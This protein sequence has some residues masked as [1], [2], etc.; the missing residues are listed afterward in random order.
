MTNRF[1]IVLSALGF[2]LLA[3]PSLAAEVTVP[4]RAGVHDRFNRIVLDWT[5]P[6]KYTMDQAAGQVS[7]QFDH[8]ANLAL[9]SF[10]ATNPPYIRDLTSENNAQ[11]LLLRFSIPQ[12]SRVQAFWSGRKV[13]F[14]VLLMS[15]DKPTFDQKPEEQKPAAAVT[16]PEKVPEEKPASAVLPKE[17]AGPAPDPN[18]T[19]GPQQA[20]IM[21]NIPTLA[22]QMDIAAAAQK[23]AAEQA[24][25]AKADAAT[26]DNADKE[27]K[28][29]QAADD[30]GTVIRFRLLE[31]SKMAVFTRS[32][33]LW[34]VLSPVAKNAVPQ[35]KG[36]LTKSFENATQI[37]TKS[38][39][40]FIFDLPSAITSDEQ[41]TVRQE[42][43][44][45][46]IWFDNAKRETPVSGTL[47][48]KALGSSQTLTVDPDQ[49]TQILP[50]EDKTL[51]DKIWVV[52]VLSPL[53]R[54]ETAQRMNSVST[55]PTILGGLFMPAQDTL[56]VV[57][58]G[59]QF[60]ISDN[61]GMLL[62]DESDRFK[63]EQQPGQEK[64]FKLNLRDEGFLQQLKMSKTVDFEPQRQKL[65]Q[66][67]S[68]EK[69]PANR[70]LRA[71]DLARLYLGQGF[72]PE[73]EGALQIAE[74][75]LP[76][77][78]KTPDFIA[79]KGMTYA[80][81]G[82]AQRALDILKDPE[83][84]DAP[85]AMLWQAY[86]QALDKNW[87]KAYLT[88][89]N[90]VDGFR[91]YP[92]Q[93]RT[94]LLLAAIESAIETKHMPEA[95]NFIRQLGD[96]KLSKSQQ[97]AKN[98]AEA[99]IMH[100]KDPDQ[101]ILMLDQIARSNDHYYRVKAELILVPDGLK[102][103][104]LSRPEAL[105][106]LEKLRFAWRGDRQEVMLLRQLGQLYLDDSQP[107]QAMTLWQEAI[108][109]STNDNDM[110]A[111]RKELQG[112]FNQMFVEGKTDKLN[113]L[114]ILAVYERFKKLM[115]EGEAGQKATLRLVD[116]LLKVD[117]VDQADKLLQEQF[118]H[119]ATG[120]D[121]VSMG[122]KLA[123]IRL[124]ARNPAGALKALDESENDSVPPE[125]ADRRQLLR[126]R[127]LAD[128]Q[129]IDKALQLLDNPTIPEGL[130]LRADL[131]W[132]QQQWGDT[133]ADLQELIDNVTDMSTQNKVYVD[134]IMR[135]AIVKA[136]QNDELGLAQMAAQYGDLM[137]DAPQAKAFNV[138][139]QAAG[140]T[141]LSDLD[142]IKTQVAQV[143]LFEN[144][145]K[146][147]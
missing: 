136:L 115:P 4:V 53:L 92:V 20:Q 69:L 127:A 5:I 91:N 88:F 29:S 1:R 23:A 40:A 57:A 26:D 3:Q 80:V 15:K 141:S 55:A 38:G 12:Q 116:Q 21:P 56:N 122:T 49:P 54:I 134:L 111:L 59:N 125:M 85:L 140:D 71:L 30:R 75:S 121:A 42:G 78:K 137:K 37:Q 118:R 81:S 107:M 133:A 58:K 135:L 123:A 103:G 14:D 132:R 31:H 131:H 33:R 98:Y 96:A 74:E 124:I 82:Q 84:R 76:N 104:A 106:R 101:A 109:R 63:A 48:L 99:M 87:E 138:M 34:I 67:I 22:Q 8:S 120:D 68:K 83:V 36:E 145:L 139:T 41:I 117:L 144:F 147:F 86:A 44:N 24:A 50:F 94:R 28:E 6:V 70:A 27:I 143:E 51:G 46:E 43:L 11:G 19:A 64:L 72:G 52:P 73:A 95:T 10:K 35:V 146:N 39:T 112:T 7:I 114:Q 17:A 62:S 119:H 105:D 79:L 100:A 142:T 45:W 18:K 61:N 93:L 60:L 130:S 90:V 110:A 25:K 108:A 65:E 89:K 9:G 113:T 102:D 77:L 129:Q 2:I 16:E 47:T 126:I 128:N 13:A 32:G 97:A 66:L